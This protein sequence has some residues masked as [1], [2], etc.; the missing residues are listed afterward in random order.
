MCNQ[1]NCNHDRDLD[2]SIDDIFGGPLSREDRDAGERLAMAQP[3]RMHEEKCPVPQCRRGTWY[4]W[5]GRAIGPCRRCKG[6]GVVHYRQTLAQREQQAQYRAR[7][8]DDK[9]RTT[10]EQA[11]TWSTDNAADFA[12]ISS[13]A[14]SFGFAA[15][16]AEALTKYGAL[17]ERQHETVTRLRLADEQRTAERTAERAKIEA[18]APVVTLAKIEE[19][20][21]AAQGNGIKRPKLRLDA[22]KFSL[23]PATGRNAGAIYVV[24]AEGDTYL[25]KIAGGRFM[26]V[27]ECSDEQEARI[28]AAAADPHAAAIAYGRRTGQCCICGRELTNHASIDLGIGPICAGRMGW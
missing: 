15:S 1:P 14:A 2:D 3:M 13:R 26:R 25:G 22:F 9:A 28:V 10:R 8:A 17:T 7:K 19:A 6:T 16:M 12:W 21:A 23:A 20:F 27:R 18:N 5:S 24:D 11:E 4:S